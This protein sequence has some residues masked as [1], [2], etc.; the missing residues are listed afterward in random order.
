MKKAPCA[1]LAV[2]LCGSLIGCQ[3]A[4]EQSAA[5][6]PAVHEE[7]FPDASLFDSET[8]IR[9]RVS[10]PAEETAL[11]K[12]QAERFIA[13]YPAVSFDEIEV[14]EQNSVDAAFM[15]LNDPQPKSDIFYTTTAD[16]YKGIGAELLAPVDRAFS[17]KVKNEHIPEA[18]SAAEEDGVLYAYPEASHGVCLVYDTSVVSA[19][20]AKTLEGVLAACQ[21]AG[22]QFVMDAGNGLFACCFTLTSGIV[23]DGFEDNSMT[24][25]FKACDEDEAVQTLMTFAKL[26][27]QYR[28]TFVNTDPAS[29]AGGLNNGTVA[30]GI[31]GVW[32]QA[33]YDS[34]ISAA[35]LPTVT[36]NGKEKQMLS[37]SYYRVLC[38]DKTCKFPKTAQALAYYLTSEDCQRERAEAFDSAPTIANL[39]NAFPG[40]PM[41]TAVAAQSPFTVSNG[42]LTGSF[43][44]ANGKLGTALYTNETVAEDAAAAKK[45]LQSMFAEIN[46]N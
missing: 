13:H 44:T 14:V 35:K 15:I 46:E 5:T 16:L 4:A 39:Q 28:G 8:N 42:K 7:I 17:G 24:Q 38:V 19:E 36:V 37:L 18:V 45:L 2:L 6:E 20:D 11:T 41:Q 10:V 3:S 31:D 25:K 30:A 27:K 26:M 34:S 12:Q 22:R 1:L 32:R 9:L 23:P 40:K 21:K 43:W 29:I 33:A